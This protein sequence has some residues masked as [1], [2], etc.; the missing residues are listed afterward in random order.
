MA[1]IQTCPSK[2]A[3]AGC[4]GVGFGLSGSSLYWGC[5]VACR[6]STVLVGGGGKWHHPG[7][8]CQWRG[9]CAHWCSRNTNGKPNNLSS[10]IPGFRQT[11]ALRLSV[12]GVLAHSAPQCSY[13]LSLACVWDSKLQ[14]L[15]DLARCG[16]NPFPWRRALQLCTWCHSDLEKQLHGHT[17]AWRLWGS[18]VKSSYLLICPLCTSVSCF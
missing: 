3:F 5:C 8:S 7:L 9:T 4:R 12:P 10:F 13:V 15:R 1:H 18:T 14:I 2:D 17:R 11:V 6:S 16:H